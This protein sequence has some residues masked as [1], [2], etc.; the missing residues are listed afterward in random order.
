MAEGLARKQFGD[1]VRVQSAGSQPSSVNPLAL[2]AMSEIGIDIRG[3]TSKS[4]DTID[5]SNVDTV[6]TLC[7]EEVCPAFLG[8]AQQLHWPLPDPASS[9]QTQEEQLEKFREVRNEIARRLEELAQVLLE[10]QY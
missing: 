3:H 1:A 4:A 5:P 8:E 2:R 7:A 9:G 10:L 6:I